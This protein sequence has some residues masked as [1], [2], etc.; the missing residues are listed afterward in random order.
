L[1]W[2]R[3]LF[4]FFAVSA[5]KLEFRRGSPHLPELGL[6]LD[7][8]DAKGEGER[9]V[10]SHA[11]ADHLGRHREV[12]LTE[13][14]HLLMNVRVGG[15]RLAHIL[16]FGEP[17]PFEFKGREFQITLLPAGHI[18]GSAMSL[19]ECEGES[20][21]YTGDF[22][23]NASLAAE[24]CQP[25]P[26]DTLIMETTFGKSRYRFPPAEETMDKI[27][28]YCRRALKRGD[29]PVLLAYSL[30]KSQELLQGLKDANLPI[31]V[32][33][34]IDEMNEVYRHC[35]KTFPRY[36]LIRD[37]RIDGKVLICP[38][39]AKL[40]VNVS[41]ED[42]LKKAVISG[43][44]IDSSCKYRAKADAAFPL[45]DHSDFDEL[46]AFVKQVNPKQ[47][48]TMH[49]FAADFAWVLRDLGFNAQALSEPEQMTLELPGSLDVE[50]A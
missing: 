22:K 16:N 23:L 44:A 39:T 20:L 28:H 34:R 41:S 3:R 49:G 13:P 32:H 17:A 4:T 11:H 18:L 46:V 37:R 48:H 19:I 31:I 35:G 1:T 6:W 33:P 7:S 24:A 10:V 29:T 14:T 21:L 8:R 12:I 30:G 45:S 42:R 36:G 9:V 40:P 50:A 43:W 5:L 26:A 38:P 47:V 27:I 15:G 2:R 25:A